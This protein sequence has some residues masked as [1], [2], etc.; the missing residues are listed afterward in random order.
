MS[1]R[2]AAKLKR[3]HRPQAKSDRFKSANQKV[4]FKL[5]IVLNMQP[6]RFAYEYIDG[7]H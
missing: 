2:A 7:S 4:A 1:I 6:V 3:R 5:E